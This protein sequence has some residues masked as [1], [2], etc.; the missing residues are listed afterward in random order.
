LEFDRGRDLKTFSSF[1]GRCFLALA[2]VLL[3][4]PSAQAVEPTRQFQVDVV[5]ITTSLGTPVVTQAESQALI[6]RVNA[7][8]NDA[9]GG[10]IRF[11]LRSVLP[12]IAPGAPVTT[13]TD[14]GKVS[15]I[16]PKADPGFESAIL[17][18][19]IVKDQSLP[20]AGMAG[21]QYML[22][23]YAWDRMSSW[24]LTHEFGHNF[25]LLHANS[26]T[27]TTVLPIVCEQLEYGDYSSVM[28]EYVYAYVAQPYIARF[29]ATELDKLKVLPSNKRSIATETGEYKLAPVY[30]TNLDIPK[31]L[32]IPIGN[33]NA[34]SVEYRPAIGGDSS[35]AQTMIN[36]SN[37]NYYTN[38]Q[39]HGLQLRII[40]TV[41]TDYLSLLPKIS[42]NNKGWFG[43]G[44]VSDTLKGPQLQ[45]LGKTLLLSDGSTVTFV[46]AD[47]NIGAVV[48]VVRAPD[49]EAPK[50]T[51]SEARW[52]WKNESYNLGPNRERL[53]KRS[54]ITAWDFPTL[55]IPAKGVSDNRSLK[56]LELEINGKVVDQLI[57]S[58]IT[59][60]ALFK[61]QTTEVGKFDIRLLASDY[62]GN[63][64]ATPPSSLETMYFTLNQP[65]V[66][67]NSGKNPQTSISFSFYRFDEG[68]TYELTDLSSGTIESTT[69]KNDFITISIVNISR[70]STI[71][72]KLTGRDELGHT[73]GGQIVKGTVSKATCS[74]SECFVGGT[75]NVDTGYWSP[76]VG[77]MSLQENVKGKWIN[78]SSAK[79]VALKPKDK[80]Y[81][82]TY[83][84]NVNYT[85]SG[86]HTYRL[87]IGANKLY[88][89][90]IGKPFKQIVKN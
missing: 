61:Y 45:P 1:F 13:S 39:S 71:T 88:G 36:S 43:T 89:A 51:A 5:P 40:Q 63:T 74:N 82:N 30:S 56:T 24:L 25:G 73:D 20:F 9:T 55:E 64:S 50:I 77:T 16:T 80:K 34:Y 52:T 26:A 44:L 11:T 29:S 72:A 76:G 27:C 79:P 22:V 53:V 59:P 6:D 7:G 67:V 35:L 54:S 19:V 2:L 81:P 8:M 87:F 57:G 90:Y 10:V 15:G 28:G 38:I 23:N 78:I 65:S 21:G 83:Q 68:Y 32:Y 17:I 47:P 41:G 75:W 70:N 31:V 62:S 3:V 48:K 14:V 85:A 84:I 49:T 46:S 60:T 33:E 58:A 37:G 4:A 66:S 12:T 69:E 18:G 42:G 86:A